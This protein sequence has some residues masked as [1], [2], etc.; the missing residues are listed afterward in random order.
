MVVHVSDPG[1]ASDAPVWARRNGHRL[2]AIEPAGSGYVATMRKGRAATAAATT[3]ANTSAEPRPGKT[4]F[5]VFSGDLDKVIA[6]FIIANDVIAMGEEVSMFF[7]FWGLNSLRRI[8]PPKRERKLMDKMFAT[9][10]PSSGG[11]M[12]LSQLNMLGAGAAMIKKV[13]K[14]NA[15][16][17]Q[18]ELIESDQAGGARLIG[19]TMTMDLLGIA[20]SDLMD[21]VE[22]GGVATFLGEA[23]ESNTTLLI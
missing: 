3:S 7:T 14:D 12:P 8:D 9:M 11:S 6:A 13:M 10:M 23:A 22:L 21:T 15:V 20:P 17:S 18:P 4:S 2:L 16:A 1:F 19:C 5:V